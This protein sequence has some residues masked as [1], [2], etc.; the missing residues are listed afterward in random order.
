MANIEDFCHCEQK[1]NAN[2]EYN[3]TNSHINS[4]NNNKSQFAFSAIHN[5]LQRGTH[6]Y[7]KK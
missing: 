7:F 2:T 5:K 3:F 1:E 4:E 6:C